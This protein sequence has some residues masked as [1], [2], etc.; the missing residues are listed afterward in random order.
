MGSMAVRN[1]HEI[2]GSDVEDAVEVVRDRVD[3]ILFAA[4]EYDSES[5][6]VLYAH[7]ETVKFYGNETAMLEHFGRIHDY[8]NIDFAEVDLFTESLF[9]EADRVDYLTTRMNHLKLVRVYSGRQGVLLGLHP[10]E[11]VGPLAGPLIEAM[12]AG[13]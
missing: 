12:E 4:V 10:D 3:D 1:T 11:E 13:Q 7:E 5:F 9:P 8:V 2:V 6:N